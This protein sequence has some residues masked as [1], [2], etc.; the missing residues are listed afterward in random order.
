MLKNFVLLGLLLALL[1]SCNLINPP[2]VVPTYV[3]IDTFGFRKDSSLAISTS[4]DVKSV[5]VY[6]DN[7]PIGIFDLPVTFP[8]KL[9]SKAQLKVFPGISLNGFNNFQ[10]V[11]P[12]YQPDTL[13]VQPQPGKTT[14]FTPIT[15]YYNDIKY[16]VVS[17]FELGPTNFAIGTGTVG[18]G[19]TSADSE[20]FEG[21][22]SGKISLKLPS[23]T[24]SECYTT[25]S[26]IITKD[27][28]AILELNY[29]CDVPF[30]LG[31]ETH[32]GT[33]SYKIYLAGVYPTNGQWKKFYLSLKDF[34]AQYNGDYYLIYLKAV[35][36]DGYQKG[37]VLLDNIQ[38]LS[39]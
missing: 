22:A 9:N 8:M 32:A 30:Y 3:H 6:Q 26:I 4:H 19:L 37:K 17:N 16:R 21:N 20:V 7:N 11:N 24:L 10:M 5:W 25:T 1:G 12:F 39:Y 34:V 14:N 2:E 15:R 28:D 36:P 18:I 27:K 13:T 33:Y 29:N 35:L 31:M 23:D 38:L